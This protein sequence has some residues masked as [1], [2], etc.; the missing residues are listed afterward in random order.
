MKAIACGLYKSR[1]EADKKRQKLKAWDCHASNVFNP[2][3]KEEAEK[4]GRIDP[5]PC[6][7]F[8]VP[9]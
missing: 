4:S 5:V 6:L 9:I 2:E 1:E 8:H 3:P 7:F